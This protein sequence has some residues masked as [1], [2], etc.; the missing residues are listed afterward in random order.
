MYQLVEATQDWKSNEEFITDK[1]CCGNAKS[2]PQDTVCLAEGEQENK[3]K[4]RTI[5]APPTDGIPG[6]AT[7]RHKGE[8]DDA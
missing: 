6:E 5:P 8:T 3:G 4:R 7:L 1:L 2:L